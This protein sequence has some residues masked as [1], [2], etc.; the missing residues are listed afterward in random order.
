MLPQI[1]IH[2][3]T[4]FMW[5]VSQRNMKITDDFH[6]IVIDKMASPFV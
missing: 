6:P 4:V 1:S 5:V 2:V 3:F